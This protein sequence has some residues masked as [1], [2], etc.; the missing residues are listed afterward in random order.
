LP[1]AQQLL[2]QPGRINAI[3]ALECNCAADRL[4]TVRAEIGKVL[5]DTQVIEFGRQALARA[6]ARNR[7]AAEAEQDFARETAERAQQ[8][9]DHERLFAVLAPLVIGTAAIWV[10]LL[11]WG[12]VRSRVGEIGILRAL[13][14]P[15]RRVLLLFLVRAVLVGLLGAALGF[16]AGWL[17]SWLGD[18]RLS[19]GPALGPLFDPRLLAL[20]LLITPVLSALVSWLPALAAAQVDPAATLRT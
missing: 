2:G 11:A 10:G 13:G 16:A 3:M 5:P 4:A 9:A 17:G 20:L 6:E 18:A 14:V 7:A 1:E 8:R 19:G 15:T 12:N